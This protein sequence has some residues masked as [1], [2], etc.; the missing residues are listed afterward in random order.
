MNES[1]LLYALAL[2]AVPNIGDI[3]AKKLINHCGSPE[4]VFETPLSMLSKIEGVGGYALKHLNESKYLK[5]A[6]KEL[7][8]MDKYSVKGLYFED[9][10]Y[11]YRLKHCIDGPIV[12]FQKGNINWESNLVIS[13]VGSRKITSYGLS[14]CEK[15]VETLAAFNPIIVSGLAYGTDIRAHKSALNHQL[16]TVACMAQGLQNTYPK[17]HL[18]YRHLIENQGGVVTDFWSTATMEPSNFIKRNRLIAGL[19]EATV[20]IESA[21][22]GGSLATAEIAFGYNREVFAL[23]GRTTDIQSQGCN[24]LIKIKS[25]H[26]VSTAADIPFILNWTLK[27]PLKVI[28]KKLFVELDPEEKIIYNFLKAQGKSTLDMIAVSCQTPTSKAVHLLLSL[29]LKGVLRP[30]PGKAFELV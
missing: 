19:S 27:A 29:E 16:Q 12:L 13:I 4:A 30:L 15:I 6:E 25:A 18:K 10:N 24:N 2:Q 21:E 23:P 11:P 7:A 8:F 17:H 28:Q 1:K 26:L 5:L 3:T 14:Q 20:I 22:K 9:S